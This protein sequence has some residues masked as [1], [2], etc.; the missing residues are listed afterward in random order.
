M[1][2]RVQE[3]GFA[4]WCAFLGTE[5]SSLSLSSAIITVIQFLIGNHS[6]KL[7]HFSTLNFYIKAFIFTIATKRLSV[8]VSHLNTIAFNL[9]NWATHR[10]GYLILLF[11]FFF[12][13]FNPSS[14]LTQPYYVIEYHEVII[15]FNLKL[16][17]LLT[18][19]IYYCIL[20]LSSTISG[21]SFQESC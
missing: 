19:F 7:R 20:F 1:S 12:F 2:W 9:W 14:P 13:F 11:L 5:L 3:A 8:K 15:S 16:S 18:L 10:K 21:I 6:Y 17:Y 4:S